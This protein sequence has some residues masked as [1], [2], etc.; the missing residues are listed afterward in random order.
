VHFFA[1]HF[2]GWVLDSR[3]ETDTPTVPGAKIRWHPEPS[4]VHFLQ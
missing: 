3:P 1:L 2:A 4:C